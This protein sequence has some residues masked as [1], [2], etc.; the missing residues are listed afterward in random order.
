MRTDRDVF[1]FFITIFTHMPQ[2]RELVQDKKSPKA[3]LWNLERVF[4]HEGTHPY[5]E[6]KWT[7]RTVKMKNALGGDVDLAN[8]EFPDFWSQNAVQIAVTKYFRGRINDPQREYSLKQMID[9]VVKTITAWGREFGHL[10]T[11]RQAAIFADELTHILLHQKA[12]F[13]SPVWFNVGVREHPQCSACFI[14]EVKDD[15]ES[16]LQ[17]IRNE[18]MIFKFGSGAGVNVSTLRS[19]RESLSGGGNRKPPELS[20]GLPE[21]ALNRPFHINL[22]RK[23][24]LTTSGERR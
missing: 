8:L 11:E 17:W 9:R 7:G 20:N 21:G 4:S 19:A 15:M 5:D 1:Q 6:V 10:S 22:R 2:I 24:V 12:A 13:N 3:S 23:T 16:I 14:L 18:G